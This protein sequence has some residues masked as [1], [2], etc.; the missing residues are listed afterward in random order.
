MASGTMTPV[1]TGLL[2]MLRVE[3]NT[4]ADDAQ[5]SLDLVTAEAVLRER[6]SRTMTETTVVT[7]ARNVYADAV[8]I[9]PPN[10]TT[11]SAVTCDD[12][13]VD[14]TQVIA[15]GGGVESLYLEPWCV[16]QYVSITGTWGSSAFTEA[17]KRAVVIQAATI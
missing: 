11:A 3:L 13:T 8:R 9:W 6:Y 2:E 10:L 1:S 14:F 17:E 7:E 16:G 12:A 5:L 15:S 4:T